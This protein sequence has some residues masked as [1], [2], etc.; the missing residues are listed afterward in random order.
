MA[1]AVEDL[2]RTRVSAKTQMRVL[3]GESSGPSVIALILAGVLVG[4][5]IFIASSVSK[6]RIEQEADRTF[7]ELTALPDDDE[8]A[9][10]GEDT[11]AAHARAQLDRGDGIAW[12]T[13][14]DELKTG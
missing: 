2:E 1:L 11:E 13:L 12:E 5:A 6:A 4:A 8:P 14:R 7:S 10:G 3:R 9:S